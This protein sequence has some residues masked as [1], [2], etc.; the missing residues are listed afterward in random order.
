[1]SAGLN[2]KLDGTK[3]NEINT[4]VKRNENIFNVRKSSERTIS[5]PE[6]Y[7]DI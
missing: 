2:A 4:T 7:R 1:M 6:T 5:R 3:M